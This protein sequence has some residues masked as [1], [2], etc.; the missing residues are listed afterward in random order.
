MDV[1]NGKYYLEVDLDL[2]LATRDRY[3]QKIEDQIAAKRE[4]LLAKQKK[5]RKISKNNAFLHEVQQDYATYYNFI[6]KQKEQQIRSMNNIKQYLNDIIVSGKL[7]EQD[8][9]EAKKEQRGILGEIKHVK[10]N[11]DEIVNETKNL[12]TFNSST[13]KTHQ[14]NLARRI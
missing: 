1:A 2:D 14:I 10:S 6:I 12:E 8:I 13:N 3:L 7:T 9:A 5:L 11:L 4:M